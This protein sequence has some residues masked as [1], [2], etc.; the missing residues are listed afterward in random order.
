MKFIVVYDPQF[1]KFTFYRELI[2]DYFQVSLPDLCNSA[3]LD[4]GLH[5][6][7]AVQIINITCT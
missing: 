4:V 2:L 7:K 1:Y 6:F 5:S 3:K